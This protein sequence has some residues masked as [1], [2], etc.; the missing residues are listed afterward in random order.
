MSQLCF[1]FT[2]Q[3]SV[4]L[5]KRNYLPPDPV[6]FFEPPRWPPGPSPVGWLTILESVSRGLSTALTV[7]ATLGLDKSRLCVTRAKS[8][9][10]P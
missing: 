4:Q 3:Y 1:L 9:M 5:N 7:A 10:I 8:L 2:I 6:L